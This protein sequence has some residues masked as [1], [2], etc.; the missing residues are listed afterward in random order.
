MAVGADGSRGGGDDVVRSGDV[1]V[2][3]DVSEGLMW[4]GW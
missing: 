2:G 1:S 3:G 4:W